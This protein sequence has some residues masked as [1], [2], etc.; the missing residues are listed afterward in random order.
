MG[1]DGSIGAMKRW[2]ACALV[3][4]SLA[5]AA[6]VA[7]GR[8]PSTEARVAIPSAT[9]LAATPSCSVAAP[10]YVPV[11]AWSGAR[12]ELP[13]PPELP[14]TPLH[15]G[16]AYTVYGA[17]HT[18]RSRYGATA[19]KNAVTIV[20]FIVDT[21]LPRAPKCALH[22]TGIADPPGCTSS[23]PT[24]TIADARGDTSAVKIPVMGWASNFANVFEAYTLYKPLTAAPATLYSDGHWASLVPYPLP[25]VGAKV[26]LKGGHSG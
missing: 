14:T 23:I 10:P 26:R 20:G 15:V 16:D 12:P 9:A 3:L 2:I 1:A 6:C 13:T 22:R 8:P 4:A 19:V 5:C 18:L 7:R 17:L 11:A 21:N 24:F 25:A